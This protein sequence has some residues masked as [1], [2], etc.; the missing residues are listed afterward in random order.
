MMKHNL[1]ESLL[2]VEQ[3][4]DAVGGEFVGDAEN[5]NLFCFTSVATDSR[6]VIDGSL[7]VPL[8]GENEDGHRYCPQAVENGA[9]VLFISRGEFEKNSE[10]YKNLVTENKEMSV[11]V[12]ENTLRALQNAA[13]RYV[14]KFPTLVKIAITG[15]SGKTTSKDMVASI[16]AR[17][18]RVVATE[19]N[20]NSETGLP[21]SVFN[22][23]HFHE[24]GVFEMGMNRKNEISEIAEILKAN[25]AL[26]T[27]IGTAHIGILGSIEDIAKEKKHVF[28]YV[29]YNGAAFVPD[30]DEF[31]DF[32]SSG[33]EGEVIRFG[34]SVPCSESGVKYLKDCGV[35]GT[36]FSVSDVKIHL[37]LPGIYN[38]VNALGAVA[39]ARRFGVLPSQIK[40]GLECLN[41]TSGRTEVKKVSAK[42]KSE[43]TLIKDC[44]NANPSSM[45]S[46]LAFCSSL[47]KT[48]K[49][50]Y[51]L[52]DMLELGEKSSELHESIGSIVAA[53]KPALAIFIGEEMKNAYDKALKRGF[54]N[55]VWI[56]KNDTDSIKKA[57]K[58]IL[59]RLSDNDVVLLKASRGICLER[60][61]DE[62]IG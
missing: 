18:Y 40:K 4:I 34:S 16:L 52:G 41:A 56:E 53:D 50:I 2:T 15:S 21:L 28:D 55:G 49:L 60:V 13:A 31:A 46:A 29:S 59:D 48:G 23:R 8:I 39:V 20:F 62:I 5:R 30:M 38:Y 19:G 22:I 33:I 9:K 51:V 25:F 58:I 32:L 7:F 36:D 1:N 6:N 24:V 44:Y 54:E 3:V 45:K 42:N 11:I 10:Y 61:A 17:K 27:N 12:V 43:I 37:A 57:A 35:E 14:S 47:E 26:I